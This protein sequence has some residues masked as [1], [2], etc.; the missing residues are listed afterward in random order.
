MMNFLWPE[1]LKKRFW[2]GINSRNTSVQVNPTCI[3]ADLKTER[4]YLDRAACYK[5][6]ASYF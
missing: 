6:V 4:L 3:L 1:I 5:S 2:P